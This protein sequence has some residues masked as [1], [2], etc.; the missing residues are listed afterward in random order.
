M[1]NTVIGAL[2]GLTLAAAASADDITD[3]SDLYGRWDDAV[4]SS[5]IEGYI[6]VLDQRVRLILPGA[7]DVEGRDNYAAFLQNVLPVAAY[8][9]ELLGEIDIDVVGDIALV[10]YHKKIEMT[11]TSSQTIT[12]PG[13]LS[14]DVSVN[15]YI[16]VLR[17]QED[18]GWKVYRHAW[19]PSEY[20][21]SQ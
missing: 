3:I 16:D 7:P 2:V 5:S 11:L 19:T 8:R 6:D 13:A 4:Q 17:R 21:L 9:L 14:S 20:A 10:E 1:V 15:K 12:E 18:G